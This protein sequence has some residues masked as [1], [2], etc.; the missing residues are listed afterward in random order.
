MS[1]IFQNAYSKEH[2]FEF[3]NKFCSVENKKIIFNK[4]SLKRAKLNNAIETFCLDLKK[5]YFPSK[6]FY[7]EREPIYKNIATIIR[8]ICKYLMIPYTSNIKYFKSKYE[9]VYIIYQEN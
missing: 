5:F 8:Q 9:I 7:L 4:E 6:H 1:Q 2:F 3:L